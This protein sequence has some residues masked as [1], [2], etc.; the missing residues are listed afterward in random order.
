MSDRVYSEEDLKKELPE[1]LYNALAKQVPTQGVLIDHDGQ[2]RNFSLTP[3]DGPPP[4]INLDDCVPATDIGA[5]V[6]TSTHS[7]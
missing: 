2:P 7:S 1:M 3:I 4:D 6:P 5:P